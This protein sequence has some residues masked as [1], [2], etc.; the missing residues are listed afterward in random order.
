MRI[1]SIV[2][3]AS[4]F[5]LNSFAQDGEYCADLTKDFKKIR[6][7]L[8]DMPCSLGDDPDCVSLGDLE[9]EYKSLLAEHRLRKGITAL[10]D[11]LKKKK[12]DPKLVLDNQKWTDFISALGTKMSLENSFIEKDNILLSPAIETTDHLDQLCEKPEKKVKSFCF[13]YANLKT[14]Q[15][16]EK[17][18]NFSKDLK[19]Y[20]LSASDSKNIISKEQRLDQI[21]KSLKEV[22]LELPSSFAMLYGPNL[23]LNFDKEAQ[24]PKSFNGKFKI[25]DKKASFKKSAEE[26]H[27]FTK[28]PKLDQDQAKI[29]SDLKNDL[30]II[31]QGYDKA[32][33]IK[34]TTCLYKNDFKDCARV[35]ISRSD[36]EIV[37][38]IKAARDL[39]VEDRD[40]LFDSN[41]EV[42][43]FMIAESFL[44]EEIRDKCADQYQEQKL[45]VS[46]YDPEKSIVAS[47]MH[48]LIDDVRGIVDNYSEGIEGS[49][50]IS[51]E[52][53][54]K[55]LC[56][57]SQFE[58]N[59]CG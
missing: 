22:Y 32:E 57:F 8:I 38:D 15:D 48:F 3:I 18:I 25:I 16:K 56:Q 2:L 14:D 7:K 11:D 12:I 40:K 53:L 6:E 51:A 5:C 47:E 10:H 26:F 55:T 52:D 45:N 41:K 13:H 44:L 29:I 42:Q 35:H 49:Q 28:A 9:D 21:K 27:Q 24:D 37:K 20:V 23:F 46:C 17:I 54:K 33:F 31:D 36:E 19:E 58:E 50:R 4:F 39:M 1:L 59:G 34:L 30:D 43:K